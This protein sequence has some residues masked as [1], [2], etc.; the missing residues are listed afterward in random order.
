MSDRILRGKP[1]PN[2]FSTPIILGGDYV[3]GILDGDGRTDDSAVD[4]LGD[5]A[6]SDEERKLRIK[7]RERRRVHVDLAKG[8]SF[9]TFDMVADPSLP[10]ATPLP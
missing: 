10:A 7:R 4:L 1:G 9:T 2:A 5:L 3:E 8:M 6:V